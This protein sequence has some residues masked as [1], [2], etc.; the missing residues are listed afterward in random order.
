MGD[1]YYV[2]AKELQK[3]SMQAIGAENYETVAVVQGRDFERVMTQHPFLDRESM[4]ILGDHVT[5]DSGTGC[6]H[7][8]PG[9]GVEDFEV[10]AEHYTAPVVVPVDDPRCLT[11]KQGRLKVYHR[12]RQPR[13]CRTHQKERPSACDRTYK[14]TSIA[15]LGAAKPGA[16]QGH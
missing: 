7:T 15:M 12:G 10:V 13:N 2:V 11:K 6:V 16:V 3:A 1:D 8:A 5:L 14:S 4:V 9:H